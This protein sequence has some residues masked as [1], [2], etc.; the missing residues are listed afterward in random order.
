MSIGNLSPPYPHPFR[1]QIYKYYLIQEPHNSF[2]VAL[3]NK[4]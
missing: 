3:F 2:M 4:I 1:A